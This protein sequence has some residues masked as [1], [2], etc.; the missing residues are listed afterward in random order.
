ME[1]WFLTENSGQKSSFKNQA[2]HKFLLKL[3][4]RALQKRHKSILCK[5][6]N[7]LTFNK[8]VYCHA[9]MFI[10]NNIRSL[11]TL[12]SHSKRLWMWIYWKVQVNRLQYNRKKKTNVLI[13]FMLTRSLQTSPAEKKVK[14]KKKKKKNSSKY[15]KLNQRIT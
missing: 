11:L 1:N 10:S 3:L 8:T 13:K 6:L 2:L 14:A 12:K 5:Q 9:L 4:A 15:K 7:R